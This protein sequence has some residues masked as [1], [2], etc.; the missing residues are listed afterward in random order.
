VRVCR[1]RDRGLIIG[2]V[3]WQ[4]IAGGLGVANDP[5]VPIPAVV[6]TAAGVVLVAITAAIIPAARAARMRPA[7]ILH[8]E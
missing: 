2:R 3:T 4:R 8:Q 6:L 1:G 5:A 7:E